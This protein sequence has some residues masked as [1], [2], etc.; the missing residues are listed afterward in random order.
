MYHRKNEKNI[1]RKR[2]IYQPQRFLSNIQDICSKICSVD[3]FLLKWSSI[4]LAL[5]GS[6]LNSY[7][8][9]KE[10]RVPAILLFAENIIA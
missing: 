10:C 2:I 1:C 3:S 7:I 4:I 6:N 8:T 9:D 5:Y